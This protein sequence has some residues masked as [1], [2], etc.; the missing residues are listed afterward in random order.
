LK[1]NILFIIIDGNIIDYL[2][3]MYNIYPSIM[4]TLW[5]FIALYTCKWN[6]EWFKTNFKVQSHS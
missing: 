6:C 5:L 1:T 3:S 4:M 2:L